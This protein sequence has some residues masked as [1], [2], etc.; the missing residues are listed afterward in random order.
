M[1]TDPSRT[2]MLSAT[3]RAGHLLIYGPKALIEDWLAWPLLG[4]DADTYLELARGLIGEAAD[5]YATWHAARSRLS[6]DW[7]AASQ[8]RQYVILGAGLDSFAW[9]QRG[10]VKV[11]EF[12]HPA[13][14]RWKRARLE[15]LGVPTP[16]M[17]EM[18]EADFEREPVGEVLKA[19]SVDLGQSIFVSW[20]GVLPYLTS[21]AIIATLA[22]LPPC[23]I[24]VS[25]VLPKSGWDSATR[26]FAD[27][28]LRAFAEL[29]EPL[30]T[31]TTPDETGDLL[32]RGGF[33]VDDDL[34]ALD[35]NA[36]YGIPC[37]SHERI[38][39]ARKPAVT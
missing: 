5:D 25:Y 24:A 32:E 35:V 20:L 2:A 36:R 37:V 27:P 13:T 16:S 3:A 12:D 28:M 15:K 10:E 8:A 11:Y 6:E 19:S 29:G 31:L 22:A 21:D 39:L 4:P 30:L 17:L 38:V 1:K 14:Q 26:A 7:L 34:G 18:V 23:T 9:R 33:H